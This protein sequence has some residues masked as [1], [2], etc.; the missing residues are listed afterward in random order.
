[1]MFRPLYAALLNG[2]KCFRVGFCL[3]TGV[4]PRAVRNAR[5]AS[6]S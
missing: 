4:V 2:W 3:I 1:M 6:L 5:K